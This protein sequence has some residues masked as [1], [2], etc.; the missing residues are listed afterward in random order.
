MPSP[1][2]GLTRSAEA[3]AHVIQGDDYNVIKI[4]HTH[5]QVSLLAYSSFWDDPFPALAT[6]WTVNLASNKCSVRHYDPEGNPPILHRKELLID[7]SHPLWESF[8]GLTAQLEEKDLTAKAP[9]LGFRKQW[10]AK[11]AAAG[12]RI[13]DHQVTPRS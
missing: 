4:A 7:P 8:T 3:I 10:H 5:R 11:L 1:T 9:G 12:V 6:A 2:R 13:E